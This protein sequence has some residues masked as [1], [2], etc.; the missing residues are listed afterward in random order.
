MCLLEAKR[1]EAPPDEP[2]AGRHIFRQIM[3]FNTREEKK[4]KAFFFF[5]GIPYI[6]FIY[7]FYLQIFVSVH[8]LKLS[9]IDSTVTH[10]IWQI[11]AFIL[12]SVEQKTQ[13]RGGLFLHFGFHKFRLPEEKKNKKNPRKKE[14][15]QKWCYF[16]RNLPGDASRERL[17]S[18]LCGLIERESAPARC[19]RSP[20]RQGAK[21]PVAG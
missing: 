10:T 21:E 19:H 5:F 13:E 16:S 3:H 20:W 15:Q 2:A 1:P 17:K 14:K 11:S 18:S 6:G 4:K 12:S 7:T 8:I 9:S